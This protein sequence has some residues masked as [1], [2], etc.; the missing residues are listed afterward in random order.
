M[1]KNLG[2]IARSYDNRDLKLGQVAQTKTI[3][4]LSFASDVSQVKKLFQNGYPACGAHA[5]S[6]LKEIKEFQER[7]IPV[8]FSPRYLWK[9]IKEIDGF[10]LEVGTNMRYILK[11][12]SSSGVCDY[13][14][15]PNV[16]GVSLKEY[17]QAIITQQMEDNA[18]VNI[19][20]SYGFLPEGFSIQELK[21]SIY[22]NGAVLML[23]HCDDN[24][25]GTTTPIF[26]EKKYGHFVVAYGYDENWIY[27]MDS[28]EEDTN[29]SLKKMN[30]LF[31]PFIREVGTVTD[32]PYEEIKAL[33]DKKNLLTKLVELYTRLISLFAKR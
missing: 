17:T 4:P 29:K 27:I 14:L 1:K 15:L 6:G 28:T 16:Y 11:V 33:I 3:I 8:A 13:D 21:E 30:V 18:Q 31:F 25:F 20:K 10:A 24:F 19:I 9:K 5:G 7:K 12:L 22:N 23:I 2:A 26:I 32:I